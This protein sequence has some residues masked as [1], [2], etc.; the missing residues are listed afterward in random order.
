M[1]VIMID[2]GFHLVAAF[3]AGVLFWLV[4]CLLGGASF[5]LRSFAVETLSG[6][7]LVYFFWLFSG[8]VHITIGR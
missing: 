4:R 5:S 1:G 7:T 3:F 6:M 8:G 2:F